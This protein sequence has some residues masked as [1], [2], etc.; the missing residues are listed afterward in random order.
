[1]LEKL[2]VRI[3]KD[4]EFLSPRHS[5]TPERKEW[6]FSGSREVSEDRSL[7]LSEVII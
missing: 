2:R 4:L 3:A 1:L 7:K 5:P 6:G